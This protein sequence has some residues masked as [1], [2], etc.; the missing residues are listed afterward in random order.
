MSFIE[1]FDKISNIEQ[2]FK[3][4]IDFIREYV[5]DPVEKYYNEKNIEADDEKSY[6]K[7]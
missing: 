1:G 7:N 5:M 4:I 6:F 3:F 2:A